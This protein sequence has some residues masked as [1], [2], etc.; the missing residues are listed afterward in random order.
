MMAGSNDLE[1]M[2]AA[3]YLFHLPAGVRSAREQPLPEGLP[4]LLQVAAGDDDAATVCAGRLERPVGVVRQAAAFY[5]EH[6]VMIPDADAFR[7]LAAGRGAS[8]I[9][10]RRNMAMLLRWAHPDLDRRG[11]RTVFAGRITRAWEALKT[12]DR[13]TAYEAANPPRAAKRSPTSKAVRQRP[14]IAHAHAQA[15]ALVLRPMQKDAKP[16]SRARKALGQAFRFLLGA[17]R[18]QK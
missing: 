14:A 11:E 10:L 3:V 4:L 7:T 8:D 1:A 16:P 17:R 6:V 13:R 9:E 12:P 15:T 2:R 18:T 5:V